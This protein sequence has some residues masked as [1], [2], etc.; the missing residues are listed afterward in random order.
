[1]AYNDCINILKQ[2]YKK[3]NEPFTEDI[4]TEFLNDYRMFRDSLQGRTVPKNMTDIVPVN[5]RPQMATEYV[6]TAGNKIKFTM[7]DMTYEDLFFQQYQQK[8]DL[9]DRARNRAKVLTLRK[10]S[11]LDNNAEENLD[12]FRRAFAD[13]RKGHEHL[14]SKQGAFTGLVGIKKEYNV[15]DMEADT[16]VGQVLDTNFTRKN[17]PLDALAARNRTITDVEFDTEA[18]EILNGQHY[19][20]WLDDRV[21]KNN[22]IKEYVNIEKRFHE[23][24]NLAEIATSESGDITA[25]KLARATFDIYLRKLKRFQEAGIDTTGLKPFRIRMLWNKR[26]LQKVG[27]DAFVNDVGPRISKTIGK[28]G[29]AGRA[30]RMEIAGV[31]Y[32]HIVTENGSHYDIDKLVQSYKSY[33]KAGQE[34]DTKHLVFETGDDFTHVL[35]TYNP[36]GKIA[37]S[38]QRMI[39]D[40]SDILALVQF[41]GPNY[42]DGADR[43][44][45]SWKS[46]FGQQYEKVSGYH[47]TILRDTEM[48]IQEMMNPALKDVV[49]NRSRTISTARTI[50]AGANLG[51]ASVTALLDFFTQL[52]SGNRIFKLPGIQALKAMFRIKPEALDKQAQMK[53]ARYFTTFG[54]GLQNG[55][56]DRFALIPSFRDERGAQRFSSWWTS[57]VLRKS[58][59][60]AI[61]ENGQRASGLTYH[62]YLSDLVKADGGVNWKDLDADMRINLEK[63]NITEADWNYIKNLTKDGKSGILDANGD[64]DLFSTLL[65]TTNSNVRFSPTVQQK[66]TSVIKDAVDTMVVKP[67]EFDKRATSLFQ[68]KDQGWAKQMLL[69]FTQFKTHPIT[70]T[71]KVYMRKFFRKQAELSGR[72]YTMSEKLVDIAYLTASSFVM[73]FV[74]NSLKDFLKGR[75]PQNPLTAEQQYDIF[76]R[77]FLTAGTFGLVSDTLLQIGAPMLEQIMNDEEKIRFRNEGLK[78]FLGPLIQD[79]NSL[80]NDSR[81]TI[82]AGIQWGQGLEDR[83]YF[84]KNV[85]KLGKY[86]LH[87]TGA[88]TFWPTAGAYRLLVNEYITQQVDYD[89]YRR[90]QK[91]LQREADKTRGGEINN[92][93]YKNLQ[94]TLGLE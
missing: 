53:L 25:Q 45:S 49:G 80:Y 71:R 52:F 47:R 87:L 79:M 19:T 65:D 69:A 84:V 67:S 32:D 58:G 62:R 21:N 10:I 73:G 44:I 51:G 91:N 30:T 70:Y 66:W 22:Y 29:E 82:T 5:E 64:V 72:D 34:Y 89:G 50:L 9:L 76:E 7:T 61:T 17:M 36:S 27:R 86:A 26:Q 93:L 43:L 6:D 83:E 46:K 23:G 41:F 77:T 39:E 81:R 8:L 31:I 85:S 54:E 12:D 78:S 13:K 14:Y 37:H 59:L 16:A 55:N 74:V 75:A 18:R 2:A 35:E 57:Q 42:R 68:N 94:G 24:E 90:K 20:E 3:A 48:Y 28:P 63:Y 11:L 60:N 56:I 1:M 40:N 33:T 15:I 38:L 88:E 92:S 4:A